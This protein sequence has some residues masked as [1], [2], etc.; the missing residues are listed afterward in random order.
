[1]T[2]G[3]PETGHPALDGG[4]VYLDYNATTPVDPRVV[5]AMLPFLTTHFGNPSSA[6]GYAESPRTGL[7]AARSQVARLI[8]AANDEIVFSGSGSEANALAIRGAVL[9]GR[10]GRR[11]V[12]TQRTEHPAVLETCQSLQRLHGV[13]ITYLPV[14]SD[15]RVDPQDLA[16]AITSHTALVSIMYAN[17]ET[18]TVQRIS[19]LANVAHERG[20]LFH[21]DAAQ[22]VGKVPLDV[23]QLDVDL[24]TIVGHKMYAP[25]GIGVLYVRTG[26]RLEPVIYGGGQEHGLRAGTE[27]VALAI[28]LGAAAELA[29]TALATGE[30]ERLREVRDRLHERLAELLPGRVQLNGHP[31]ERLPTTANLAITG[32][33]GE[34]LLAA[35]PEVAASTGSACHADVATP[36]PVLSAM[37]LGERARSSLRLSVGRWT[38][39][40]DVDHAAAALAQ[41][42]RHAKS[43][44]RTH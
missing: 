17:N 14:D 42:A 1:M 25:K 26:T 30:G 19:E 11:Q 8:K 18:G 3:L 12:I 16:D 28:A 43:P 5:D 29:S 33:T 23:R 44:E 2:D 34:A 9:A 39:L 37:G 40:T 22:A 35:S 38:T 6:H 20:V 4:P 10:P 27:P 21:T 15:G 24:L 32:V 31:T 41:A 13:E 7:A 36:S